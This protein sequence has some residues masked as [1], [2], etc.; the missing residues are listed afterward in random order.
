MRSGDRLVFQLPGGSG[1]ELRQPRRLE[2][3]GLVVQPQHDGLLLLELVGGDV[4]LHGGL[5]A[6]L[7]VRSVDELGDEVVAHQLAD[8]GA[9]A[10]VADDVHE[11]AARAGTQQRLERNRQLDD[12][13][14]G[15][16][17]DGDALDRRLDRDVVVGVALVSK[18]HHQQIA[19]AVALARSD[20]AR[21][22]DSLE[23][24]LH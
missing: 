4:R 12:P 15:V 20:L 5:P 22:G 21:H 9:H 23:C 18:L 6:D 14:V 3:L 19:V 10:I 8:G 24:C 17:C 13:A 11:L 7:R 2:L 16:G 1:G